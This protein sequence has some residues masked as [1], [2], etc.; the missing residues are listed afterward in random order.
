MPFS[1]ISSGD[2]LD[3]IPAADLPLGSVVVQGELVGIADHDIP[4]GAF[5]S[6]ALSGV[7]DLP[8]ASGA[9]VATGTA[10]FWDADNQR[11]TTD[12]GGGANARLGVNV[13]PATATAP[14]IRIR[15]DN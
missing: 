8:R 13:Q 14:T 6:L 5:G 2:R 9:A 15:L 12:A 11:A 10:H 7:F 1:Y 3:H 4:A